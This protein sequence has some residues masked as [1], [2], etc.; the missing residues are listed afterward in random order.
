M[1]RSAPGQPPRTNHDFVHL[2][3]REAAIAAYLD[4][5]PDGAGISV[6]TPAN[7]LPYGQCALRTALDRL[8]RAGHLRR[9][10]ERLVGT[11]GVRWITRSWFTR[12]EPRR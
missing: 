3:P 2:S 7:V 1:Q 10:R 6:K 11:D 4:R 12:T 5:L 9:G 8:Q